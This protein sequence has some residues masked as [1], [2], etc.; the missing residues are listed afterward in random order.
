M[1]SEI[2]EL[3]EEVDLLTRKVE[4]LE[5]KENQRKAMFYV[6][7]LIKVILI[8]VTIYG[9]YRAYDYVVKEL[10]SIIDEKIKDLNPLKKYT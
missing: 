7:L 6:K 4:L 1:E 2:E 8:L 3:R 10:P 9:A 5:K